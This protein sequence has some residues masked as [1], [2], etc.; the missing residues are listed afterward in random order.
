MATHRGE[1]AHRNLGLGGDHTGKIRPA[2]EDECGGRFGAGTHWARSCI[3]QEEFSKGFSFSEN[4][5]DRFA[6]C[7]VETMHVDDSFTDDKKT[8][9]RV[10][11]VKEVGLFGCRATFGTESDVPKIHLAEF[12]ENP[13][14]T[15]NADDFPGFGL[16]G[17]RVGTEH[18]TIFKKPLFLD[19]S[20]GD[21]SFFG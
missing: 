6:S 2:Y 17:W 5:D 3:C 4:V 9:R 12:A 13:G 1:Q 11:F 8:G 16:A 15:K 10:A 14:R 19:L 20:Q 21:P 18:E 7:F